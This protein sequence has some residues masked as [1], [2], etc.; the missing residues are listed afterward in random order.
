[1]CWVYPSP[2]TRTLEILINEHVVVNFLQELLTVH[3]SYCTSITPGWGELL[4]GQTMILYIQKPGG[5]G[6]VSQAG[7]CEGEGLIKWLGLNL[8]WHNILSSILQLK[9]QADSTHKSWVIVYSKSCESTSK[10]KQK[11]SCYTEARTPLT[12]SHCSGSVTLLLNRGRW[13][14]VLWLE[15][16]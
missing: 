4:L 6:S 14:F 10:Q 7:F 11:A 9:A 1:M 13:R 16:Q 12:F 2:A 3:Q 15:E 8:K 5:A